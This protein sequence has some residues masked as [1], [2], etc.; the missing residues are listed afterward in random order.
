MSIPDRE[1]SWHGSFCSSGGTRRDADRPRHR[2]CCDSNR[3][4]LYLGAATRWEGRKLPIRHSISDHRSA[5]YWHKRCGRSGGRQMRPW[6]Y[7][8]E[9]VGG[10]QF[11]P[12]ATAYPTRLEE[13]R[14]AIRKFR[15][16]RVGRVAI[17][18]RGT[19]HLEN[20]CHGHPASRGRPS[21]ADS[22]VADKSSNQ[23]S[24]EAIHAVA[25]VPFRRAKCR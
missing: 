21:S 23:S 10:S 1:A 20:G 5:G 7:H 9:L 22:V 24:S 19:R 6:R 17:V 11:H 12:S 25:D 3:I 18:Q 13:T 4:T 2:S 16:G 14:A 15:M 8:H